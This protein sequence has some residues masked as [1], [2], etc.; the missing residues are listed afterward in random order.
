MSNSPRL[1]ELRRENIERLVA[2]HGRLR[3]LLVSLFVWFVLLSGI[4]LYCTFVTLLTRPY[5]LYIPSS[6]SITPAQVDNVTILQVILPFWAARGV[7]KRLAQNARDHYRL[8]SDDEL[9]SCL[10]ME[11]FAESSLL[12]KIS[13]R[14]GFR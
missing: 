13:D 12:A 6:G 5:I 8:M 7:W 2:N 4:P 3:R 10:A 11:A 14:L 9:L 1:Q